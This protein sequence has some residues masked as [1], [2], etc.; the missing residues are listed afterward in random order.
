MADEVLGLVMALSLGLTA[1]SSSTDT[2]R[3]AAFPSG[4]IPPAFS[5]HP[6]L[7]TF[8]DWKDAFG[9]IYQ[10]VAEEQRRRAIFEANAASIAAH[11]READ[12]G[13]HSYWQGVN[14]LSDLTPEEFR[15]RFSRPGPFASRAPPTQVV[16][17]PE[18]VDGS[19]DWRDHGAVTPVK[20]Q[21]ACGS[22]WAFSTTGAVEGAFQIATGELR[23][24]SEQQL[25]DC[26]TKQ[27]DHGCQGGLMDYGFKYIVANGGIDSELDYPYL[28]ANE[29]CWTQ[30]A[31][32]TVA[33]VDAFTDVPAN[34]EAQLAAAVAM[35]PVSVAIEAD[36]SIFQSYKGGVLD[37]TCGT[38]LDH[39]V[40]VVGYG[41][42][43]AS[44]K[45]Y[46]WVKNSWGSSWGES[47]YVRMARNTPHA[48]ATGLCGI[49]MQ[50]SY[51]T[52]KKGT[53]PPLPPRTDNGTRP[54]AKLCPGCQPGNACAAL[55]MK[56]CCNEAGTMTCHASS[57]CC[58]KQGGRG[59]C[60]WDADDAITT[61]EQ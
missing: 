43:A 60:G 19:V 39:G 34:D 13:R 17:L 51:P 22:C 50:P 46:W 6:A 37:G 40:L 44:G 38:K 7:L 56:C 24:L 28:G 27:G 26:S 29:P 8:D 45:D 55:G 41:T 32:R 10:T 11:N 9:R 49:A 14:E 57:D 23:S 16:R 5:G 61:V 21:G 31:N 47:G 12:A 35:Q 1:S 4:G 36:Q 52:K 3:A 15:E 53:A 20:N 59:A 54:L 25:V 58:C 18:A 30:A 2:C 48:N 42:D 33:T